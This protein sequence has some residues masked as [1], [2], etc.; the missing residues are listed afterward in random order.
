MNKIIPSLK[1]VFLA[2]LFAL[3]L[4]S[5]GMALDADFLKQMDT[6]ITSDGRRSPTE[7]VLTVSNPGGLY[8]FRNYKCASFEQKLSKKSPEKVTL[9]SVIADFAQETGDCRAPFKD[10]VL[11]FFPFHVVS[12]QPQN[13]PR[14]W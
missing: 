13:T 1:R 8:A 14:W 4:A 5:T 10:Q 9:S 12:G 11:T 2:A 6:R 3:Y 7:V